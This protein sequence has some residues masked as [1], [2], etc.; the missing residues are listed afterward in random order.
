VIVVATDDF[1]LYHE[2]VTALRDRGVTFTTIEPGAE[3]P[4][5]ASVLITAADD[6]VDLADRPEIERVTAEPDEIRPAVESALSILREGEGRTVIGVDPGSRPGVAVLV[7]DTVVG[8]T[9]NG[10]RARGGQHRPN[11][12]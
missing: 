6:T 8:G 3:L 11:R 12:G 4:E 1:R 5:R 10:R 2:A 7:G 9:R